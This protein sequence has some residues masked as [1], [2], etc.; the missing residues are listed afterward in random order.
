V[1]EQAGVGVDDLAP[2]LEPE[3][4]LGHEELEGH[5]LVLA[6]ERP[7]LRAFEDEVHGH[8][9]RR[10]RPTGQVVHGLG[11]MAER[12]Q[13]AEKVDDHIRE[14]AVAVLDDQVQVDVVRSAEPP[15]RQ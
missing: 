1:L 12:V 6:R 9:P 5:V 10:E 7:A 11:A 8:E 3:H 2:C 14:V 4:R 13:H 15:A